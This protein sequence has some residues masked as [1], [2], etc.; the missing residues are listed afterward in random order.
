MKVVFEK[1]EK[2]KHKKH[3]VNRF[4]YILLLFAGSNGLKEEFHCGQDKRKKKAQDVVF[5]C[6]LVISCCDF[7]FE[8]VTT[9]FRSGLRYFLGFLLLYRGCVVVHMSF[10]GACMLK[11]VFGY[12]VQKSLSLYEECVSPIGPQSSRDSPLNARNS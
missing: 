4:V 1:N 6:F 5:Y 9:V 12:E 8:V 7:S 2:I 11:Q 3:L 10:K